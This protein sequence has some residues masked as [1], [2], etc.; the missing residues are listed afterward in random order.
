MQRQVA[1]TVRRGAVGKVSLN[2]IDNSLAAYPTSS[3]TCR[4]STKSGRFG[5]FISNCSGSMRSSRVRL[6]PTGREPK[7]GVVADWPPCSTARW[8]RRPRTSFRSPAR[9]TSRSNGCGRGPP[10]AAWMPTPR[11][12]STTATRTS[13]RSRG[14]G[15][16]GPIR[17]ITDVLRAS[18]DC[19]FCSRSELLGRSRDRPPPTQRVTVNG[20]LLS[21]AGV[22]V[23]IAI[24]NRCRLFRSL[25]RTMLG[26]LARNRRAG[27]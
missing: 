20:P 2:Y 26:R 21:T 18:A 3:S 9:P 17:R 27:R 13:C 7:S 15:S 12:A 6:M 8:S 22:G 10:A 24:A 11:A 14:A 16:T 1:R 5:E 25:G 4:T 19:R 23:M